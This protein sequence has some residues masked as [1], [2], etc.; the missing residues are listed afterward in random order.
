MNVSISPGN[1]KMGK[2]NSVSLPSGLTCRRDAP[3]YQKCY[4]RKIEGLRSSVR[5]AYANNY[6]I[7]QTDPDTYWREVEASIM[8]SRFFR[9]HVS[10]DIPDDAYFEKMIAVAE[11]NKHSQIM[12]FTKKY[13]IVNHFIQSGG[14]I[15]DNLH[16]IFSGWKG[17]AMDNPYNLPEAHVK[18][19][20]GGT[21][22]RSDAKL[23]SGNCAECAISDGG[24]W[25][26]KNGEQIV[27]NEH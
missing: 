21:T 1:S 14:R 12:C 13:G 4:A 9:F 24:C 19:K 10:G 16:I 22:A 5:A 8:M 17:L 6:N 2:I 3:C 18:Y 27:F 26:I 25:T 20:D 23:C 15:P 7:L 11:R